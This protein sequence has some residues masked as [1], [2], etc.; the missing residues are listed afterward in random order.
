VVLRRP[1]TPL[2]L[3]GPLEAL[4][5][6]RRISAPAVAPAGGIIVLDLPMLPI[7]ATEVR[8]ALA[9]GAAAGDLLPP[10]VYAYICRHHLYGARS[11]TGNTA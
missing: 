1:G 2:E 3:D 6:T 4:L 10:A 8:A 9:S 5:A 7:S 11:D